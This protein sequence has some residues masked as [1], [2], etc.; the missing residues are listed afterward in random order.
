MIPTNFDKLPPLLRCLNGEYP[1]Q[2]ASSKFGWRKKPRGDEE[3]LPIGGI[4]P[5]INK[6]KSD[7]DPHSAIDVIPVTACPT[8]TM[9]AAVG[10]GVVTF[11]GR[12]GSGGLT[13][14][15]KNFKDETEDV[16]HHCAVAETIKFPGEEKERST[17]VRYKAVVEA[18]DLI[19]EMGDT[20]SKKTGIHGHVMRTR[21]GKPEPIYVEPRWFINGDVNP[22]AGQIRTSYWQEK[23]PFKTP[24]PQPGKRNYQLD[25]YL[26]SVPG[27]AWLS[28]LERENGW[29]DSEVMVRW[30][31]NYT[32]GQSMRE[33][34]QKTPQILLNSA[35]GVQDLQSMSDEDLLFMIFEFYQSEFIKRDL[36]KDKRQPIPLYSYS[37]PHTDL[38]REDYSRLP[39][40][41]ILFEG[42]SV[43]Y[44][45]GLD[46]DR[47]REVTIAEA[48]RAVIN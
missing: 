32:E 29:F 6:Y 45:W 37:L 20:G 38:D 47:N 4:F 16:Y 46:I 35:R 40:D 18:G 26:V 41:T 7:L 23:V 25:Q 22:L 30:I 3:S 9:V 27:K 13:V 28:A 42:E 19:C 15:V 14:K 10:P 5:E 44:N 24:T 48:I 33:F 2:R 17:I 34:V 31:A 39:L 43:S 36:I 1:S 12:A 8:R 21:F 11:S